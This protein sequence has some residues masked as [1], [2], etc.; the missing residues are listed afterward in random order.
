MNRRVT[1]ALVFSACTASTVTIA[2]GPAPNASSGKP[3]IAPTAE[4]VRAPVRASREA[5][6]DS[7]ARRCLEF[8]TN[9]Q[10]IRCA[11][12]YLPR[13]AKG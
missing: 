10:I 4:V 1:T 5:T 3:E 2:Q 11:E 9:P 13:R 12:K 6:W 8:P 7:D